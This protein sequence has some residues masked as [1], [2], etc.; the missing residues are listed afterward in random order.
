MQIARDLAGYSLGE[1]DLLRRAMGKKIRKEMEAQRERFHLRRGRAR[2]RA[3]SRPRRFSSLREVRRIR[4]QQVALRR[5]RASHLSDRLHEGELSGRVHGRLDDAEMHNTDKLSEYRAEAERL[6]HQG[7]AAFDQPVGRRPSRW[8]AAPSAMR[9]RRSKASARRPWRRS[10]RRAATAVPRPCRFR[11]PHQSAR[12]QQARARKPGRGR[13][14]RRARAEPG[15]RPRRRRRDARL[16]A[17]PA[18][19]RDRRPER[20]VRRAVAR[21]RRCRCPGVEPWLPAE[22]LQNANTTRSAFSSPGIRST[23]MRRRSGGLRVQPMAE[24]ARA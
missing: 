1:A 12:R 21:A 20:I 17:A 19:G 6:G 15:A 9:W 22:R 4:L 5:L 13:R 18:R 8:K 24:F 3:R 11:A 23:T 16:R 2:R 10:L 7:R 14:V